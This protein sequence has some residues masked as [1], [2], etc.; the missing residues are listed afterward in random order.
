MLGLVC[1]QNNDIGGVGI[2]PRVDAQ[3]VSY[4]DPLT[5][6]PNYDTALQ[7]ALL[8]LGRG[9]VL[10]I[11]VQ[12]YPD[13]GDIPTGTDPRENMLLPLESIP[14]A[15]S[16]IKWMIDELEI[17]VVEAGGDGT[18]FQYPGLDMDK[19][20]DPKTGKPIFDRN[21]RDS[22]A[23]MVSAAQPPPFGPSPILPV[24]YAPSGGRVDCFA[25]GS[26]VYTCWAG[27]PLRCEDDP[28]TTGELYTYCFGGTSSAAAIVVG[29][30]IAVQGAERAKPGN[31]YL[32]P[33][34]LR[35][36][37]GDHALNTEAKDAAGNVFS[38]G[39]MPNL[40][41]LIV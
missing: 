30:A 22:G 17:V 16:T 9:D 20:T 10:L 15:Y 32:A 21:F 4:L 8:H 12:V 26:D 40:E 31:P 14:I 41:K 7:K 39:V 28:D 36:K 24:E 33:A 19:W 29:A 38:I 27:G 34:A 13:M 35:Q 37:L 3:V 25:W 1:A 5:L 18:N 2:A 6:E 23:I 11:E